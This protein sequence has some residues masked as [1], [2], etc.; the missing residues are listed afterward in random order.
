MTVFQYF[1]DSWFVTHI[2]I[3]GRTLKDEDLCCMEFKS[4]KLTNNTIREI[5]AHYYPKESE[6]V[7]LKNTR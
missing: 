5:L 4:E 6:L 3:E 7:S 1:T 2:K